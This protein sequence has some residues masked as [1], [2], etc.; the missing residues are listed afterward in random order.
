DGKT[1]ICLINDNGTYIYTF[2]VTGSTYSVRQVSSYAALKKST[3]EGRELLIGEFN[4]D[5]KPDFLLS[6]KTGALDWAIYYAMGNGQFERVAASFASRASTDTFLTQDINSDGLTDI[7]KVTGTSGFYTYITRPGTTYATS[8]TSFVYSGSVLVPTDINSR[9]YF[10]Q[11]V[12]LKDGKVTRF[13]FPRNDTKEKLLTGAVNSLGVVSKNHYRMLNE[14]EYYYSKGYGA[15]YPFENF[16]GPFSF[17][18]STEQYVNGTRNEY[19]EYR[20]DNAVIH[21]QGR[22]FCGF[23]RIM[24]NDNM[25]GRYYTQEYDPY[26]FG[27]LKSDESPT[28][29]VT[30]TWTVSVQSNKIA[31]I[32]LTNRSALNRL[33][34]QTVTTAYV[35]DTYGNV[36]KESVN[37]SGGVTAVTDQ[38]YYNSTSGSIY[39]IGQPVAKTVTN[40]RAGSSWI[41]K[42]TFTYNSVRLPLTRITHT[43]ST[44]TNKTRETRWTYDANW[45]VASEK[46]APYNVTEFLG[47]TYTYDSSGRYIASVT[48][49]LEQNTEYADFDRY[50][51]PRIIYDHRRRVTRYGMDGWGRTNT[52]YYADGITETTAFA[53]GGA[54]LYTVTK[55]VTGSPAVITHYDALGREIRSG[56]QRFD[57]QWQFVDTEYDTYGRISRTSLPFKGTSAT[58]WNNY[59]YDNYDRPTRVTAASGKTTS[60]SYSGLSLTETKNGI[61]KTRTVDASG[62]LISVS[63]PGG[64]ITYTQR[65]D[66]Q[67]SSITAPGGVVTSF[68]YDAFGRQTAL[69]DPSAGRQTSTYSY[70]TAGVLTLTKTNPKGTNIS[71]FDKYGRITSL[72]RQ[73]EF[74]TTYAYNENGLLASESS[75]NGTSKT[76]TYDTYDRPVT[77]K[78]TVPDSKWLQKTITYNGGN[79][80]SVQYTS[81]DGTIGT[82]NFVHANGHNTEI[83]LNGS[84]TIWKLTA[85]NAL[86]QATAITTGSINRSYTYNAVGIPT[87]RTAGSIQNFTYNFDVQK[88]NLLSRT[89]NRHSKTEN[90]SYDNLN[91][92][93]SAAGK[94][95]TYAAN[96]NITRIEG[97]GTMTYGNSAKPYQVTLLSPEGSAVPLRN[98]SVAYTSFQRPSRVDENGLSASF[99]YNAAGDRVKMYVAN[100]TTPVLTRYYIG[101]QYEL[102][103]PSNTER[104]Y[105]GGDAYS[106]PAVY[107]KEAG[108]WKIY[109]I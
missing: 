61:A 52:V 16:Q 95:I 26:N 75:T 47:D 65:P 35:Y 74:T 86:G 54:G 53:W 82:E 18:V 107:V 39:L 106:A 19:K 89:D 77:E 78:E 3:L 108:V 45:N 88:G 48:N 1:D 63:D 92:L 70:T 46:S 97:V 50:G 12:A 43:G 64:T 104:L 84:T 57:G 33:T 2:D 4:G 59:N 17:P 14:A 24:I 25:R 93:I 6:P 69:V 28:S 44:G 31:K 29:K 94:T 10:H 42:E 49:A 68:E 15:V 22:G 8:Y 9:N 81:Q 21:K 103:A 32:R 60:W 23:G 105:L 72:Q 80:F 76:F 41:D 96:G 102:D 5:G 27:I 38:T 71:V 67:P 66:G 79:V 85:E 73:G 40:T 34:N 98:Q 83:K 62:A 20:Y 55:T 87:G 100:G 36:T 101:G 90:F 99:T 51:N 91:R 58:Q 37:Y 7:V 13:S 11:L 109:Y 30:N 56:N